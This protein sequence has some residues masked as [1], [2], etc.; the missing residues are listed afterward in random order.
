MSCGSALLCATIEPPFPSHNSPFITTMSTRR[1]QRVSKLVKEQVSE[2]LVQL[3]LV[4]CGFIT[5]T[6]ADISPD[7]KEGRVYISVIGTAAQKDR[8][9]AELQR[10]RGIIQRELAARIVLKYTPRLQFVIDETESHAQHIEH[11]L[12]E[13]DTGEQ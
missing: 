4:D 12:D 6:G 5:V 8:A 13:L 11:L 3:S 9:L 1:T 10:L 7:L 2:I